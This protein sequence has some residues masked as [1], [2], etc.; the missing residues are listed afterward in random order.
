VARALLRVAVR[1]PHL[2]IRH[3]L[4][5]FRF[6][7]DTK[8]APVRNIQAWYFLLGVR[9]ECRTRAFRQ[10]TGIWIAGELWQSMENTLRARGCDSFWGVVGAHNAPLNQL[11]AKHDTEVVARGSVQGIPSIYYRKRL[12]VAEPA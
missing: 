8:P 11:F 4:S 10:Q 12:G 5:N 7:A 3:V 6:L 1:R 9:P 2:V